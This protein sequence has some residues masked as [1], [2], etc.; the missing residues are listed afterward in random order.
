MGAFVSHGCWDSG[1]YARYHRW[2]DHIALVG[3]YHLVEVRN[4]IC[5]HTDR[6]R[7]YS[8]YYTGVD[9]YDNEVFIHRRGIILLD[10]HKIS[11]AN[12]MGIWREPPDDPL[13]VLLV[14]SDDEG[15]IHPEHAAPLADRL[16][17]LLPNVGDYPHEN[18]VD[19]YRRIT[20]N[21]I[22][23]LRKAVALNEKVEY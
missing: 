11:Y 3:G 18:M 22:D 16:E 2:R 7:D 14:H 20:R 4:Y 21:F 1:S 13:K 6:E 9:E 8:R 5:A 12:V 19:E 10:W 17:A 23:G 15:Y